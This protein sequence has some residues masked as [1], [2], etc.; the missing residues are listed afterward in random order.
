M[1]S[2]SNPELNLARAFVEDTG[3]HI[4]LT[5]KAGTG[6]TTFLRNLKNTSRKRMVVV[7]PTGVAAINAGG[8]TIHSFFQLPFSPFVP[9]QYLPDEEVPKAPPDQQAQNFKIGRE[10]LAI[11]KTLDLLVIDEI[12]MVRADLL[13]AID[14]VLRRHRNRN[15]SFGGVQ[16]L[17]IGDLQQLPPVVKESDWE[18]LGRFYHSPFFFASL[19]LRNTDYVTIGL[20][21]VYRQHDPA[22]IEL[23]NKVRDNALDEVTWNLLK[24]RLIPSFQPEE[25]EGYITLTTHNAQAQSINDQKLAKLPGREYKF[26]AS[27]EGE[28]QEF[29]FPTQPELILKKNAQVMFVKND[30][31]H[32]K[33]YYNGKLGSITGFDED[34]VLVSCAGDDEAIEV[35]PA[36]WQNMKYTLN[37]ETHEINERITGTFT[38]IP[39]KLAWA[40][41]IHKS[42]GLT[43]DK[44]IIDAR[45]AFAHGQV[46]VALSRCRSLEGV[47]LSTP[48]L[49]QGFTNDSTV[50]QF[51]RQSER[52]TPGMDDLAASVRAYQ[53]HL[54]K[55]LIDFDAVDRSFGYLLKNVHDNRYSFPDDPEPLIRA[56][57][58]QFRKEISEVAVKFHSQIQTLF[59]ANTNLGE[60][61]KLQ[62]RISKACVYFTEKLQFILKAVVSIGVET[63]NKAVSKLM[64]QSNDRLV[65]SAAF[66]ISC[67]KACSQGFSVQGYLDA[68][69]RATFSEKP[70]KELTAPNR[71]EKSMPAKHPELFN[72]IRDWRNQKALAAG[73]PV[74]MVLPLKTMTSLATILPLSLKEMQDVKG[75]GK[76]KTSQYGQDLLDM[77]AE[78]CSR[79]EIKPDPQPEKKPRIKKTRPETRRISLDLFQSGKSIRQIADIR[80]LSE[81]TVESHLAHFVGTGEISVLKFISPLTLGMALRHF[82]P[83]DGFRM[84]P[85][86][87]ILGDRI[88]WSDL[89]FVQQHARFLTGLTRSEDQEEEVAE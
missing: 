89:R 56:V 26:V 55:E 75:M 82:S 80:N 17:M 6:K 15:E 34:R 19:A 2:E 4:F 79:H 81:A 43:F 5:G 33:R 61:T 60:N 21:Q 10:K 59:D 72:Q 12:S 25:K 8:V 36:E 37:E 30:V 27:I 44:V 62:E 3:R 35:E 46:Y 74:F 66:K 22:F 85:V 40:I 31:S 58:G 69:T 70:D 53:F 57:T 23:L 9:L 65:Q 13:D 51:T 52:R 18:L 20:K 7:A 29:C 63:D 41:T 83:E 11:I 73:I 77:I 54:L 76:K 38:Q 16:L 86:K 84:G 71:Q 88:S 49:D 14:A 47:V 78:F 39:L 87:E 48:L 24:T 64:A 45:A 1:H 67:L 42:Q 28:F 50:Q 32:E 68:R